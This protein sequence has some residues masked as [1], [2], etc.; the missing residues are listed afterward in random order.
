MFS[1]AQLFSGESLHRSPDQILQQL[2][3]CYLRDQTRYIESLIP[4]AQHSPEQEQRT[5]QRCRDWIADL[6]RDPPSG[7]AIEAL[8]Q[9][10]PLARADGV[11]LMS[12]AEA[13]LRIPDA[14][15]ADAFI[16]DRLLRADWQAHGQDDNGW[17]NAAHQG[18]TLARRL[19]ADEQVGELSHLAQRLGQPLIRQA[20]SRAVGLISSQFVLGETIYEALDRSQ[21]LLT[22]GDS[23][24]VDMLGEAALCDADAER[25]FDAYRRAIHAIGRN[26]SYP[27]GC[28][29]PSVSIKLSALHPRFEWSQRERWLPLLYQR[30]GEL[31]GLGRQYDIALTLDAEESDRLEATLLLFGA[32]HGSAAKGWGKFGIAVQ[33]YSRRALVTL[34]WLTAIARQHK[35]AIPIRL[36]K[37]AYWDSEIKWAQQQ[38][39]QDYPVFTTKAATDIHYLACARYLFSG[40]TRNLIYPQFATHNARTLADLLSLSDDRPFECQRLHGMGAALY[41]RARHQHPLTCRVYGPVGAQ[42]ELLPYL[43]RRL[44]ENG[45]N[46]SFVNQIYQPGALLDDL[47]AAPVAQWPPSAPPLATPAALYLP[48]RANSAGINLQQANCQQRL[49]ELLAEPALLRRAAPRLAG[50]E[51]L[52]GNAE[53]LVSP[54]DHNV[55]IGELYPTDSTTAL[56]ALTQ[57]HQAA[58]EW[59]RRPVAE[60]ADCLERLARLLEQQRDE[61]LPL[62]VS[63]AGKTVAAALDEIREAVDFCYY[64]SQQARTLFAPQQLPGPT[65]E[66]NRLLVAPK[67]VFLCIS[68]WNF[69]LAIF[70]GQITAALVTGNGVLAKPAR[71][72]S[73]IAAR[74]MEL[75]LQAGIP[76]A[77]VALLPGPSERFCP[78]LL[79][80][81]RVDGV[82]FTGSCR[83]AEQIQRQLAARTGAPI[84]TLIAETGGQNAMI[85]DS[86]ALPEQVV[87]DC[88]ESAFGSAGQRCS[89]LRLLCV[90]EE[91]ADRVEALLIGALQTRVIGDPARFS[92]DLGPVIDSAAQ[93]QLL[94]YLLEQEKQGRLIHQLPLPDPLICGSYVA[95][96]LIRL[97][98]VA[99]LGDEQFGPIL[100]LVRYQA[101]DSDRLIEQIN[102]LGYGLTLS[103][104]SRNSSHAERLAARARVGNIYINRHQTGAVVGSQPFGGCARSGTGPKAG[105]PRYLQRFVYEKH[106]S[107]NT[108]AWGGNTG[109]LSR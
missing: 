72:G 18:L 1:A 36:T 100:H 73:L 59:G 66:E 104:H 86:S 75:L 47:A 67:G 38:G 64:Y 27:S 56:A 80:D 28:L 92:T 31:I 109:L 54:Q 87:R 108:S 83:S 85:V 106:L 58:A 10:F 2:S 7:L 96:A 42:R 55:P 48:S 9:E 84:A 37:G 91:I 5:Q 103:I 17:L 71:Q 8:L 21:A 94:A 23:L 19:L 4:F 76:A 89:A 63:E 88:L 20:L 82:A 16:R 25:Y 95:P 90:Q 107:I 62:L 13:L 70:L 15:T 68:P 81:P 14:D 29:R 50:R 39:L 40:H 26:E 61:L 45:A 78:A 99:E 74:A 98:Q 11:A 60:R 22:Q 33:A 46:S 101:A 44:L 32:L 24:S 105:G 43:V 49:G 93:R 79:A 52:Q 53:P 65:G 12:L 77:V 41:A 34:A 57:V 30:V 51:Q 6:R 69:P 102:G 35:T 97:A 3:G